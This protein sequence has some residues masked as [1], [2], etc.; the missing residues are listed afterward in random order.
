ME[1]TTQAAPKVRKLP[2]PPFFAD[3]RKV[4]WSKVEAG[5]YFAR[6]EVAGRT[7]TLVARL[8][9]PRVTFKENGSGLV[10]DETGF[11]LQ[12]CAARAVARMREATGAA[13]VAKTASVVLSKA[14]AKAVRDCAKVAMKERTRFAFDSVCVRGG[15]VT[16]T[17]G[18]R[19]HVAKLEAEND[20]ERLIPKSAAAK[21]E[22]GEYGYQPAKDGAFPKLDRIYG[23]RRETAFTFNVAEFVGAMTEAAKAL[24][25]D[26]PC[27]RL[28][29][30]ADRVRVEV[31]QDK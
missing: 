13:D 17:D 14:D 3:G 7:C 20:G 5:T 26:S 4:A 12:A 15:E 11:D 25:G 16:A 19:A 31:V 6:C 8:P 23:E 10:F 1:S 2:P 22:A 30:E 9:D 28:Y 18:K 21:A 27:V 29:V 24:G